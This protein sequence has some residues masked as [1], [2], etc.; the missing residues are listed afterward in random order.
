MTDTRLRLKFA[1]VEGEIHELKSR[2][3]RIYGQ[4]LGL[5]ACISASDSDLPSED[6]MISYLQPLAGDEPIPAEIVKFAMMAIE[7]I[8]R[9]RTLKPK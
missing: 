8:Q 1:K 4:M 7:Q 6:T 9:A 3:D 2:N 5:A